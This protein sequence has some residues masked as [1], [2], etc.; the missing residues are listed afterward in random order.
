M[1][2][3]KQRTFSLRG[4][5]VRM[6]A[7]M[8]GAVLAIGAVATGREMRLM[9]RD[10][11][12]AL[13][14]NTLNT[15]IY[16]Q[17]YLLDYPQVYYVSL[18]QQIGRPSTLHTDLVDYQDTV[19][20]ARMQYG[21]SF[22]LA[23]NPWVIASGNCFTF[24]AYPTQNA[25]QQP[26]EPMAVRRAD[27]TDEATWASL[28]AEIDSVFRGDDWFALTG[29]RKDGYFVPTRIEI[30]S[31]AG[32]AELLWESGSPADGAALES[33]YTP[34]VTF[35]YGGSE[36]LVQIGKQVLRSYEQNGRTD[37]P[38]VWDTSYGSEVFYSSYAPDPT[39]RTEIPDTSLLV[40]HIL[41]YAP[42]RTALRS[43]TGFYVASFLIAAA[44]YLMLLHAYRRAFCEPA[45][46]LADGLAAEF[47]TIT[48]R[49]Q[50]RRLREMDRLIDGVNRLLEKI[51]Q[52]DS[53]IAQQNRQ[54]AFAQSA[55]DTR[56]QTMSAVAHELKTPLAIIHSAAEGLQA[57]VAEDKRAHYLQMILD[58]AERMDAMVFE[59]L[60][61]SRA[62]AGRIRL[63]KEPMALAALAQQTMDRLAEA[64]AAKQLRW[65]LR[66][67]D[68]T[69]AL[70]DGDR[71]ARVMTNFLTNAIRHTPIGGEIRVRVET[72]DRVV[73]FA[74][75]NTGEPIPPDVLPQLWTPFFRAD[76]A[77]SH[78]EGTGLG[79]AIAKSI[80]ALHGGVCG[81]AN[82]PDG[83]CFSF[84]V[85]R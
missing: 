34:R 65:T 41:H 59:M 50:N 74:V 19:L 6:G 39:D 11:Y 20:V 82:T 69:V 31:P 58:E 22:Q 78:A 25:Q 16:S 17:E 10:L 48:V 68:D 28:Q 3:K 32:Q 13:V 53:E 43:L 7:A 56:K 49:P 60:D 84:A 62:E 71:I 64:A 47:R 5:A 15:S 23:E 52:R 54:L 80:V 1:A 57:H 27:M 29:F 38:H 30:V 8:L 70:V 81:A 85:D 67:D 12:Y 37:L 76:P 45:R 44:L 18:T 9:R 61:L 79:L 73:R 77:R 33:W 66:A 24:S 55:E 26:A 51:S 63:Y 2:E 36:R 21:E 42:L 40:L 14:N 75:T 46:I 35:Y 4:F 83:V 72:T